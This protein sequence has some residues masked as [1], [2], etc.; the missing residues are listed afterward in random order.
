MAKASV[1]GAGPGRAGQGPG[2]LYLESGGQI[3]GVDLLDS[4][5]TQD[6]LF[7]LRKFQEVF[8]HQAHLEGKKR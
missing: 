2:L 3:D 5:S 8:I 4:I 1:H 7:Q 6:Q